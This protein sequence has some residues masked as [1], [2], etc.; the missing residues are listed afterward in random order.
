M[1]GQIPK[2]LKSERVLRLT[3]IEA[4]LRRAYYDQLVDEEL[5]LLV[6][7]SNSDGSATGTSCRYAPIRLENASLQ[8]GNLRTVRVVR[9]TMNADRTSDI[10]EAELV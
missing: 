8:P 7:S 4:E 9:R 2:Q 10:L 6:E 1:D 3:E 5:Q